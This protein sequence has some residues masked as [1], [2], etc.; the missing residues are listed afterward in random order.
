[1]TRSK[2]LVRAPTAQPIIIS[3]RCQSGVSWRSSWCSAST[4]LNGDEGAILLRGLATH[5][6]EKTVQDFG[7]KY[8]ISFV[9]FVPYKF[10]CGLWPESFAVASGLKRNVLWLKVKTSSGDTG[11]RIE[12]FLATTAAIVR[13]FS[14]DCVDTRALRP[15]RALR[16]PSA[17]NRQKSGEFESRNGVVKKIHGGF[18]TEVDL[19]SFFRYGRIGNFPCQQNVQLVVLWIRQ[20]RP[21]GSL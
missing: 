9:T 2:S 11:E 4:R 16:H 5:F 17:V 12:F 14:T 18:S 1:M 15:L 20:N 6:P 3:S 7:M 21:K 8:F 19:D 10:T 13:G